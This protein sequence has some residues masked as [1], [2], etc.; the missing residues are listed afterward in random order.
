MFGVKELSVEHVLMFVIVA[1]LLYH[2]LGR[3]GCTGNGFSVGGVD[4]EPLTLVKP[5][6][7]GEDCR[8]KC[9]NLSEDAC[10]I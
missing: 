9:K 1:F 7:Q 6:E 2:L 5:C 10:E 4:C 3:C 8:H